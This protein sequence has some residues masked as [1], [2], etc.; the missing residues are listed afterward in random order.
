MRYAEGL[1]T[2]LA[3]AAIPYGYTLVVW[4]SGSVV[5]ERHGAPDVWDVVLF[6][7]GASFGYALLRVLVRHAA[8]RDARGVGEY[9]AIETAAVQVAAIACAVAG[10]AA[11]ARISGVVP[12]TLAPF[13]ATVVYLCGIAFSQG[14]E[15]ARSERSDGR[16]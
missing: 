11:I 12:W 7:S 16:S 1:R 14:H 8:I 10:A 5:A 15:I 3:G 2:T 6:V 9:G 13:V 4:S